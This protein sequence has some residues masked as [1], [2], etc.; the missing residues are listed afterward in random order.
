[1]PS[2]SSYV[3]TSCKHPKVSISV[4]LPVVSSPRR[5]ETSLLCA[6][7]R[8][9]RYLPSTLAR[10]TCFKALGKGPGQGPQ[11]QKNRTIT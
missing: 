5:L 4:Q 1:M 9:A 8:G 3:S 7:D 10:V 11:Q 2:T 6:A